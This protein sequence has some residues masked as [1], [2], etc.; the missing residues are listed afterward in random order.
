MLRET[1]I[2]FNALIQQIAELNNISSDE[3]SKKFSVEPSVAQT[4]EERIQE[5]S[6]FLSKINSY[7]VTQQEGEKIGVGVGGTVAS[8]T[9]TTESD[10][11]TAD[12]HQKSS[13]GYRAEQTNFDTHIRYATLDA[14]AHHPN[15]QNIVTNV[16]LRR[17][18]L[19]R[20]CIGWNGTS[21]AK[22]TNR[23]TNPLL[24]DVNIGWLQKIRERA[25]E[26][27][28][29]EVVDGSKKVTVGE[30][31]DY[32]NLDALVFDAKNNLLDPWVKNSTDLVVVL[33]SKLM[34]DKYFPLI[35]GFNEPTEKLAT[36]III[37]QKRMGGLPIAQVPFMADSSLLITTLENLSIYNQKGTHRRMIE[38]NPKRDRIETYQSMNEAYVVE[39]YGH[40]ALVDNIVLE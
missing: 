5:S 9:D 40:A 11:E 30:G 1:R 27:H 32:S 13:D 14:W 36:D 10:R 18:A 34:Q 35:N 28:L 3:V 6:G 29:S 17:I 16:I 21:V 22:N 25:Q 4:M 8:R 15:F 2:Q 37:S 23:T 20:I 7:S 24:E 33:G 12:V 19:D 26:R 38:D 39:D 31:K